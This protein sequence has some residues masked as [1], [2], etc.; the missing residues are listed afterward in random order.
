MLSY[1]SFYNYWMCFHFCFFF[2]SRY[3][4]RNYKFC[5][6]IKI[7]AMIA[8]IKKYKSI[9]KKNKKKHDKIVLLANCKLNSIEVLTSKALINSVICHDEFVLMN[10]V[11]KEYN[12]MKEE[13]K[14]LKTYTVYHTY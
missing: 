11:L 6:W 1:F 8:G 13:R 4:Y 9:I 5:N 3:S 7:C 12:K 10:N 2:F 14:N